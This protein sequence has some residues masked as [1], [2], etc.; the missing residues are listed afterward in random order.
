MPVLDGE[1]LRV[2]VGSHLT[3]L[4]VSNCKPGERQLVRVRRWIS[5]W[6]TK[7]K[8][9]SCAVVKGGRAPTP[10]PT[11]CENQQ[12]TLF[13]L[14]AG[15]GSSSNPAKLPSPPVS[16]LI[17]AIPSFDKKE[18][19]LVQCRWLKMNY[20]NTAPLCECWAESN[21]GVG[22]GLGGEIPGLISTFRKWKCL[23]HNEKFL[24]LWTH[25]GPDPPASVMSSLWGTLGWAL[26]DF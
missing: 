23:L 7:W 5:G 3:L 11:Q 1:L 2:K 10:S 25:L 17:S 9:H 16:A 4:L 19:F 22:V 18:A 24:R 21:G 26:L 12:V 6:V 14:S 20:L 13:F 8:Q 15:H